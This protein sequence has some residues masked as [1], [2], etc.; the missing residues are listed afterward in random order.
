MQL[1]MHASMMEEHCTRH[2]A[3]SAASRTRQ[4]GGE[5]AW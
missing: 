4:G 5:N 2:W 1:I 3:T